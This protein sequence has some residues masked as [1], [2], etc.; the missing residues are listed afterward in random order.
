MVPFSSELSIHKN[1]SSEGHVITLD[2]FRRVGLVQG[3]ETGIGEVGNKKVTSKCHA[4]VLQTDL[5]GRYFGPMTTGGS[6]VCRR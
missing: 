2:S 6:K 4:P 3:G 1:V 5:R